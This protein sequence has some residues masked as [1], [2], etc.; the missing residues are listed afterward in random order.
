[1]TR[2]R[3]IARQAGLRLLLS[4]SLLVALIAATSAGLYTLALDKAAEERSE[5]LALFYQERLKQIERD[6]E[7]QSRDFK[8][9]IE[10]TRIL[11]DPASAEANLQA[12]ITVQGTDR[13]FQYL[14]IE[15]RKGVKRFDFG[16]DVQLDAIPASSN[17]SIGHYLDAENDRLY[18][19]FVDRI[20]LGEDEGMGRVAIFYSLDNAMIN[21]IGSPDLTLSILH[22]GKP[23]ASSGGQPAIDRL[24]RDGIKEDKSC[25]TLAWL[26]VSQVAGTPTAAGQTDIKLHLEAPVKTLFTPLEMAIVM[27]AIPV[28][29]GL[30]LWFT[31]GLWLM[32]QARRVSSLGDAVGDYANA[33]QVTPEFEAK[34]IKAMAVNA[35]A[36]PYDEIAEVAAA[37]QAMVTDIDVR[38]REQ[39]ATMQRISA[40]EAEYKTMLETSHDGFWVVSA[41]DGKFLDVN[42]A[43]C[44]MSGYRREELLDLYVADI[45]A[46]ESRQELT[47]HM[48]AIIEGNE[49]EA[50][51]D[52]CHRHKNG[53]IIDVDVSAQYLNSRGGIFVVFLR[54]IS[55]QKR[56]AVA[57][58]KAK[59]EAEQANR[60]KSEFLA[61]MSHEIRTPMNAIIGLSDLALG[62]PALTPKL[63]DYLSKIYASSRALLAI[64]N[65][66][67][68]Y[69][70]VEAGRL[71]LEQVDFRLEELLDNVVNLFVVRAEE[72]GLE[73]VLDVDPSLPPLL[74]GDSLRLGQVL[75]N[76]VGNAV[77][78]TESGDVQI[79]VKSV[80][81]GDDSDCDV[82]RAG[83]VTLCFAVR[84]SGIGMNPEQVN[85]LFNAFTQADGSITRRYGGTGL[86]L[87]ISQRLV[88]MMGGEIEV[89]S[90]AGKGSCFSFTICLPVA[91]TQMLEIA[92]EKLH[93]MRVLVVD[94]LAISRFTLGEMLRAWGFQVTEAPDGEA[95]LATIMA[96]AN[97]P[98]AA[99]EL[100]LLDWKMPGLD[101]VEVA[102]RI[103]ALAAEYGWRKP[104]VVVM[105]TAFSR[106]HLLQESEGIH[107]DAILTKPVNA[108]GM[109]AA[110]MRIQGGALV[111]NLVVQNTH[112]NL[113]HEAAAIRGAHV[114]LVEDNEI[115]QTVA[116]DLLVRLGLLVSVVEHGQ[117]ALERLAQETFDI[118]LMD[119]Q[120][121]VMDGFEASRRIRAEARWQNLPIIAMTAAVLE[122]DR[123]ACHAA[124]MNDHVAKPI[125]PSELVV[126]LKK[127][128]LPR[129]SA[130]VFLPGVL[131]AET[132]PLSAK[133]STI[134]LPDSLPGFEL[135]NALQLM[136]GNALLFIRLASQFAE[137]FWRAA[138][139]MRVMLVHADFAAMAT[140][141]HTLKGAAGNLGANTL[142]LAVEALETALAAESKDRVLLDLDAF[143][144]RMDEVLAS[145]EQLQVLL[146][147]SEVLPENVS[148]HVCNQCQWQKAA[149]MFKDL[150]NLVDNYDYIPPELVLEL[151]EC[152]S[153]MPLRDQMDTLERHIRNT[154]YA[155][156]Q[157][158]LD[159][160]F[161]AQ[162]H[163]FTRP[164]QCQISN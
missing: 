26:P 156:A 1:V 36:E 162:G 107:L 160:I 58:L 76:L 13:R 103:Q 159:G 33:R 120:M 130:N 16:K 95:A 115:N 31:L 152:V 20:W 44:E 109:F 40:S 15:D 87:A 27:G 131:P 32:R 48:Q 138:Q 12:F 60:A 50:H 83:F 98:N 142:Y 105:V 121:P 92:P 51:F 53:Q 91:S 84:D 137:N 161:C 19:V 135:D 88:E 116:R 101:G 8:V 28:V 158:V 153:C 30:I 11:E 140:L 47:I 119:L 4:L 22:G 134:K 146:P 2:S 45:E 155:H 3:S 151:K 102:R 163:P 99:F 106:D 7:L 111:Q 57:L 6:W 46:N 37:M 117:A 164:Q 93:A 21:Q 149:I 25:R 123:E 68:D 129:T 54:D 141:A 24:L 63:Q 144:H 52:T 61:N 9:R 62:L 43:Y 147:V 145:I 104:P 67:L 80:G 86:G 132:F 66:I 73:I 17:E 82:M 78:F 89:T 110:I 94:D 35:K 108:S 69:S 65:D 97:Q 74:V 38:E 70:K 157:T 148:E 113:V 55:E 56:V 100:L 75:N 125:L 122:R 114:L 127:W 112:P 41:H 10:Y 72:K 154:D 126:T 85:R 81:D 136:G 133:L 143:A 77:K 71:E 128:L 42:P 34:L 29:D 49:E 23:V 90:E 124:G 118:V 59:G 139:E 14:I 79:K 96:T 150:Q 18:R 5:Q 39:A 64:I